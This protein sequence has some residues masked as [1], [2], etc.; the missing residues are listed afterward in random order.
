MLVAKIASAGVILACLGG[1]SS[2]LAGQVQEASRTPDQEVRVTAAEGRHLVEEALAQDQGKVVS[3]TLQPGANAFRVEGARVVLL[4][5]AR[6]GPLACPV[7]ISGVPAIR[8]NRLVLTA[9]DI[10]TTGMMCNGALDLLRQ[11]S[12]EALASHPWDL[13]AH[14]AQASVRP[15]LPGPRL[16][17]P[18]CL[19]ADQLRLRTVR[20]QAAFLAVG[21]TVFPREAG[22]ACG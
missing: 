22:E 16:R 2:A 12:L 5:T 13:A 20:A 11:K 18:G 15:S 17:G 7:R 8:T 10:T 19:L 14:L 6:S 4:A 3:L 21:I 9:P 1:T